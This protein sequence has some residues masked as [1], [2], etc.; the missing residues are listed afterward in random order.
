[1]KAEMTVPGLYDAGEPGRKWVTES[2][3]AGR[4][5]SLG[6]LGHLDVH[7][8]AAF[9]LGVMHPA[10]IAGRT[11][12]EEGVGNPA[13]ISPAASADAL[14]E[15]FDKMQ[16]QSGTLTLVVENDLA[17][18]D[19]PAILRRMNDAVVVA[20]N[21]YHCKDVADLRSS[22]DLVEYLGTSA[23]GYPLNAFLLRDV[24][25]DALAA[26]IESA[27]YDDLAE[28]LEAVVNSVFDCEGYSVWI[29]GRAVV[30]IG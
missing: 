17:R 25:C 24:R 12:L 15:L 30:N 3:A 26:L 8:G 4:A 7:E 14:L 1:L 23:S 16:R 18:P 19:D 28:H 13:V 6:L 5:L 9:V 10:A 29:V 2:L 11:D 20:T 27:H 22:K 21:V